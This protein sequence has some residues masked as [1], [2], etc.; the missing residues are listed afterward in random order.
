MRVKLDRLK[1][2]SLLSCKLMNPVTSPVFFLCSHLCNTWIR[3]LRKISYVYSYYGRRYLEFNLAYM[4]K[5]GLVGNC[6]DICTD[7]ARSVVGKTFFF[8]RI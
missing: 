2:L 8:A 7:G 6:A 4:D 3:S 5:E 1:A